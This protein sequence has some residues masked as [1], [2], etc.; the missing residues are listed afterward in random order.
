MWQ[1]KPKLKPGVLRR[2]R[3]PLPGCPT[4]FGTRFLYEKTT[5]PCPV[6]RVDFTFLPMVLKPT[7]VLWKSKPDLCGCPSCKSR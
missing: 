7:A 4:E 3:C 6:C 5:W 2:E 1:K